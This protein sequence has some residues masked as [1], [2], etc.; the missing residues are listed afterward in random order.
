MGK[1]V[2][3]NTRY[4]NKYNPIEENWPIGENFN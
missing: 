3:L 4:R 1:I 2:F